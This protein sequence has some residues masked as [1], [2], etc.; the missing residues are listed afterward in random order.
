MKKNILVVVVLTIL[1]IWGC[2]PKSMPIYSSYTRYVGANETGTVILTSN[3]FGKTRLQSSANAVYNALH[4][5]LFTGVPGSAYELP[6]VPSAKK[7]HPAI[8]TL[9]QE[10]S[11]AFVL[12]TDFQNEADQV[13]QPDGM[14]GKV[15]T[16]R[17]TINCRALRRYLEE[18]GV[19]KEF[20]I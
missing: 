8:K 20:G 17:I 14:K 16:C 9:L 10:D 12:D 1:C 19:I 13:R 3:G 2:S 11:P 5:L 6:M 4:T 15:T 18:Q 7:D